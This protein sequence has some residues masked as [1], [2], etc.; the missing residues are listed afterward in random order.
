METIV[1][2]GELECSDLSV[3]DLFVQSLEWVIH[4][5]KSKWEK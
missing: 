3:R 2:A 5:G 4:L 1:Y